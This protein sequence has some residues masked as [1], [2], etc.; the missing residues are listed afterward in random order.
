L[1]ITKQ[2]NPST[3]QQEKEN[4]KS[5]K[6]NQPA[7]KSENSNLKNFVKNNVTNINA[8]KILKNSN[9]NVTDQSMSKQKV[10]LKTSNKN[11]NHFALDNDVGN[12]NPSGNRFQQSPTSNVRGNENSELLLDRSNSGDLK[13][14]NKWK[15]IVFKIKLNYYKIKWLTI[16]R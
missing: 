6:N 2:K 16:R 9:Q 12:M 13:E 11:N 3:K 8:N 1:L 4:V 14:L 15:E 7:Q 10:N 5:S